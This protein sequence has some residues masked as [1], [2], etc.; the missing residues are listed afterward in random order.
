MCVT[1]CALTH[2]HVRE[3]AFQREL[4]GERGQEQQAYLARDDANNHVTEAHKT[5]AWRGRTQT[6]SAGADIA[7]CHIQAL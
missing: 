4:S 5:A 2:L 1:R 7:F 6:G 3:H